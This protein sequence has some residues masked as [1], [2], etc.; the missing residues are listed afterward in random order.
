MQREIN[1]LKQQ[2]RD[3]DRRQNEQ[4]ENANNKFSSQDQ[5]LE[6]LTEAKDE[7]F[8]VTASHKEYITETDSALQQNSVTIQRLN[9]SLLELSRNSDDH[10]ATIKQLN[11]N[12][13]QFARDWNDTAGSLQ[14]LNGSLSDLGQDIHHTSAT[15]QQLNESL[16]ELSQ[17]SY[18][19]QELNISIADLSHISNNNSIMIQQLNASLSDVTTNSYQNSAIIQL[20]N[21]SSSDGS[22]G[23]SPQ[24]ASSIEAF[25][26]PE[27]SNMEKASAQDNDLR[28][29]PLNDTLI[30]IIREYYTDSLDMETINSSLS[31]HEAKIQA[32]NSSI[33]S[34]NMSA[35]FDGLSDDTH[36]SK[37]CCETV[38]LELLKEISNLTTA[39]P[40]HLETDGY[41]H[42]TVDSQ[43]FMVQ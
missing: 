14:G 1:D 33:N 26:S 35:H 36:V 27:N 40:E 20:L 22:C 42:F 28:E 30:E 16:S 41:V 18:M 19:V 10:S 21:E 13:S 37:N 2:V 43:R 31:E 15:I 8:A 24:N 11:E 17:S 7:L 9:E 32:L 34:L 39:R 29:R 38:R 4:V 5:H 12:L 3:L 23:I 25:S 6:L